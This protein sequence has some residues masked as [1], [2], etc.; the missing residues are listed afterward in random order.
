R[1]FQP[2][3]AVQIPGIGGPAGTATRLMIWYA[4]PG[5]RIVGHLGFPRHHALLDVNTP[6]AGTGAIDAVGRT[7]H[8]VMGPAVAVAVLPLPGLDTHFPP[9]VGVRF[10]WPLEVTE[11]FEKL[12]H[13]VVLSCKRFTA[14]IPAMM[15][16]VVTAGLDSCQVSRRRGEKAGDHARRHND[17]GRKSG[18]HEQR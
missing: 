14:Y 4:G 12:T 9:A 10:A 3:G 6:T 18:I 5:T 7:H 17:P 1:V 15:K 16:V 8:L 2:I 11:T 13:G